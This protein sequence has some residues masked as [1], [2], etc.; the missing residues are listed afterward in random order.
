MT[1]AEAALA[2]LDK[3][4]A[5]YV[6]KQRERDAAMERLKGAIVD[7]ARVRVDG[8][9]VVG[10]EEIYKR[11]RVGRGTTYTVLRDAGEV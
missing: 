4:A 5:L 2:A 9:K 1:P 8:V 7:V 11:A 10:N 6:E 3:A